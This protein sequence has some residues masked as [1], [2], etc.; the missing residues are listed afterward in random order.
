MPQKD[1]VTANVTVRDDRREGVLLGT[2]KKI[3]QLEVRSDRLIA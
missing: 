2:I 1:R 3:V